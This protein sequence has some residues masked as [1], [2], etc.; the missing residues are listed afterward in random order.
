VLAGFIRP[1][2]S[3]HPIPLS[4]S[5]SS[6][7]IKCNRKELKGRKKSFLRQQQ[8]HSKS[9]PF[10]EGEVSLPYSPH[11]SNTFYPA[12]DKS[13]SR[14]DKLLLTNT[15][16]NNILCRTTAPKLECYTIIDLNS[17]QPSCTLREFPITVSLLLL[18][19]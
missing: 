17:S 12:P 7:L 1:N 16:F 5:Y 9:L 8:S 18:R 3:T 19:Q 11:L 13:R 2:S 14:P 6:C 15:H 10:T 4:Y